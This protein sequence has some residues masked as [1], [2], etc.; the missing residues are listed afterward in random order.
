[1]FKE[2]TD[3]SVFLKYSCNSANDRSSLDESGG[4]VGVGGCGCDGPW[5]RRRPLLTKFGRS[6][7]TWVLS[8]AS[9]E[10]MICFWATI[11]GNRYALIRLVGS[12]KN[13]TENHVTDL[14]QIL[15]E[16]LKT[17]PRIM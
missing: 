14:K 7:V 12:V 3:D 5:K 8:M 13:S 17:L 15:L 4:G 11:L 16:V 9:N 2:S 1:M 10:H 6:N